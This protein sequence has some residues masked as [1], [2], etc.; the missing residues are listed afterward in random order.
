[1]L[2]S[3]SGAYS[4]PGK[5][6]AMVNLRMSIAAILLTFDVGFA[7]GEDGVS[8]DTGGLDTF[9]VTLPS[10]TLKF[11]PRGRTEE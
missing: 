7:P 9:V 11:E 6:L 5:N 8:F 2:T 10:L 1:M 4:C 3:M